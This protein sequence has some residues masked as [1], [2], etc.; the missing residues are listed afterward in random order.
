MFYG[1]SDSSTQ[2]N[3]T[4]NT[5]VS[6]RFP[7]RSAVFRRFLFIL[8]LTILLGSNVLGGWRFNPSIAFAA[9]KP[10][11]IPAHMTFQQFLNEMRH[12]QQNRPSF[13]GPHTPPPNPYAK[14]EHFADYRHLPPDA[15]PAT[16]QPIHETLTTAFLSGTAGVQPID[17]VGSDHRLEVQIA[18]GSLDLSHA[19]IFTS[20]GA[21]KPTPTATKEITPTIA[22]TPT[23]PVS[24]PATITPTPSSSPISEPLTLVLT[25]LHGH[26]A[27]EMNMLGSYQV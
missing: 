27:G 17:L 7:S 6:I 9:T 20:I 22:I 11:A 1:S 14:Y 16:M 24:A 4:L 10:H 13:V 8:F 26:F 25:E 21:A 2:S 3:V 23:A 19:S 15:E 18:P 12:E 5:P